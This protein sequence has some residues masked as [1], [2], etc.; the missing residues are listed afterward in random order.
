M[1]KLLHTRIGHTLHVRKHVVPDGHGAIYQDGSSE[2]IVD[3]VVIDPTQEGSAQYV[4]DKS[5]NRAKH[6]RVRYTRDAQGNMT[7]QV[8]SVV[9]KSPE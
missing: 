1:I 9:Y 4:W 7:R 3:E 2:W 6:A 8:E 5:G